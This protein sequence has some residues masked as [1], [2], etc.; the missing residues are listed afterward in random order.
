MSQVQ[1]STCDKLKS[2]LARETSRFFMRGIKS[3]KVYYDYEGRRRAIL[4]K[5]SALI[6]KANRRAFE[7]DML[8]RQ[9]ERGTL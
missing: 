8:R 1:R 9:T 6:D 4:D 2:R 7:W 5:Y 3:E